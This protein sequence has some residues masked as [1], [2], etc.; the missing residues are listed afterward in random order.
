MRTPL[1]AIE[2]MQ[3]YNRNSVSVRKRLVNQLKEEGFNDFQIALVLNKSENHVKKL[4][5]EL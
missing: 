3:D 5:K 2:L 1:C 4:R